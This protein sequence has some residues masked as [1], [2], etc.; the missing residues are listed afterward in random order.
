MLK[1]T[2]LLIVALLLLLGACAEKG[3]DEGRE[4]AVDKKQETVTIDS[5]I[6]IFLAEDYERI[7]AGMSKELQ[8]EVTEEQFKKLSAS[9][10]EDVEAYDIK[11]KLEIGDGM[12]QYTMIS[13]S[14]EKGLLLVMGEEDII[15]GIQLVP[16]EEQHK[17]DEVYT[18]NTYALP[19]TGEW[20]VY[21]GGDNALMNY[22]YD[23]PNQRYAYDLLQ[24]KNGETYEGN[25]KKNESYY[26]F[27][28]DYLAPADGKVV[29]VVNDIPDNE[30]VGKMNEQNP[31]GNH[32]IIEHDEAE[33]SYL[34]H[35][36]EGSI[37]VTEGDQVKEGDL[38]GQVGNSGNSSEPHIHFHIADSADIDTSESIRIQ[39]EEGDLVQGDVVEE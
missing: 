33:F 23:Y 26:A 38:L 34:A 19:L 15:E 32:V 5:F 17:S 36:K 2:R 29:T 24:M 11:S 30:P 10:N 21:W 31:L 8:R 14:R 27:G 13:D 20:V 16:I 12:T 1:G 22:H 25:P 37:E 9:Y 39:L 7:Y 6:D 3:V 28:Q 35:F 4:E 18:N